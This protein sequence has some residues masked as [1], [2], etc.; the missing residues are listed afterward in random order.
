MKRIEL[1]DN[2][3]IGLMFPYNEKMIE[4]IKRLANRR[5][6]AQSRRWEVHLSHLND[7]VRILHIDERNVPRQVLQ[8]YEQE[9][10]KTELK[11]RV[12]NA[13]TRI[14]GNRIPIEEID[15][16]TCFWIE[17]AEH[18]AKYK[19]RQWD[20]MKHL[21]QTQG[22]Y[23]F[24]TGLLGRVLEV[25]KNTS[26]D[27]ELE[28]LR[29][30]PAA[31]LRL[32]PRGEL[33]DYQEEVTAKSVLAGKGILQVATGAGK[34]VMAAH[35]IARLG[36][37]TVF[38]VHT[39]DLL[40]QAKDF[41]EEILCCPVWQIGDG[42]VEPFPVTVA[43]IQTVSRAID[44]SGIVQDWFPRK[45]STEDGA[46][47]KDIPD[48]RIEQVIS[49]I[50]SAEVIF[51]DE[52]HHL[53]AET[54]FGI[55]LQTDNAYFR[56]GLSATPY[57][58]DRMDL[59][60]EAAV[61]EKICK[62]DSSCLIDQG[63][64]VAPHIRFY[65]LPVSDAGPNETYHR[66][67]QRYV[68]RNQVRNAKVAELALQ[69][70]KEEKTVL[71]LVTQVAHG[72]GLH[73][74]IPDS[75]LLTGRDSSDLRNSVLDNLRNRKQRVVIAT[76]LADEGLDIPSLDVLILAGGGKSETR[77]LQRIG[78]ALRKSEEKETATIID[79]LDQVRFLEEHSLRRLEI[80]RTEP[81]FAIEIVDLDGDGKG[82]SV[83]DDSGQRR[84]EPV[85]RPPAIA[86]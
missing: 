69:F 7:V 61:G 34:T 32:K 3:T 39:K 77:A 24:P 53:P 5:W 44:K 58:S 4:E 41:F 14:S 82:E 26:A 28:D 21:F 83:K 31:T 10:A 71:V 80:Y 17:G 46:D 75:I 27:Y 72:K 38:F 79:F 29:T 76:T 23:R 9:W 16:C 8:V 68:V 13:V 60:I 55:A 42:S 70:A 30:R 66:I 45:V 52:C 56:F 51:F 57:R 54:C 37:R 49:T 47:E 33:R 81:R 74:L 36:C 78:R 15:Q 67:Y 65:R 85:H 73:R 35:I 20:G 84:R 43:T 48:D 18:S 1:V 25:L 2:Q 86:G 12:G 62:I 40:Y 50:K 6:N 22:E 63:Y 59:L 11:L 64:L 19:N